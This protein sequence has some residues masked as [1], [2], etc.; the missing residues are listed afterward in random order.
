MNMTITIKDVAADQI[1]EHLVS[2]VKEGL[3]FRADY[4][5]NSCILLIHL[6]GGY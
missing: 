5:R 3:T 6:D 2:F 4:D 1:A